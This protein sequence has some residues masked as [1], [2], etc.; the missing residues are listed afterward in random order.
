[1]GQLPALL[2]SSGLRNALCPDSDALGP[3]ASGSGSQDSDPRA[4]FA[5]GLGSH[6]PAPF[7]PGKLYA[8]AG[9]LAKRLKLL[10]VD[11]FSNPFKAWLCAMPLVK[12]K[13]TLLMHNDVF[14]LATSR[15]AHTCEKPRLGAACVRTPQ[16]ARGLATGAGHRPWRLA[17]VLRPNPVTPLG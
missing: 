11:S 8:A 14:L 15:R 7:A 10:A 3:L 6:A 13:Y 16:T 2:L 12:T 1:M 5:S 9:P 17:A 4:S